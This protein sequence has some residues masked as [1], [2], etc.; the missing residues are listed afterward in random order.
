[1]SEAFGR[2]LRVWTIV[3]AVTFTQPAT[4]EA[5]ETVSRQRTS[6]EALF[7][8]FAANVADQFLRGHRF[9]QDLPGLSGTGSERDGKS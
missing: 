9:I 4:P 8:R 2:F 5:A 1:L 3:H 6:G 7:K